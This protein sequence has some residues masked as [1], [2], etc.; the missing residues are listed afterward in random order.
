MHKTHFDMAIVEDLLKNIINF[1]PIKAILSLIG[2]SLSWIFNGDV[3]ILKTIYI[4]IGID[5]FLGIWYAGKCR[6][7]SSRG[8]YRVAVKCTIYFLMIIVGRLV[9]KHAPIGFAAPIMDSFLVGTEA[10]S[11]LENISKLGFPVPQK[12][13]KLMKV[14]YEKK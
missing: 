6:E 5:T 11:I 3:E 4:L 2:L 8:F 12:L 9:D 1:F 14:S 7:L 13:I 10:F